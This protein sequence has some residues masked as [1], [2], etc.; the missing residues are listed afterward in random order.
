MAWSWER[1]I[2][3]CDDQAGDASLDRWDWRRWRTKMKDWRRMKRV[4]YEDDEEQMFGRVPEPSRGKKRESVG[5]I[6]KGRYE[7]KEEGRTISEVPVGTFP[8]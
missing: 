8:R 7:E 6:G 4:E 5:R 2:E 3:I 1:K